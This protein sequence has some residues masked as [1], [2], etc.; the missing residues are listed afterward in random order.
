MNIMHAS[1]T[2]KIKV[3]KLKHLECKEQANEVLC[4]LLLICIFGIQ[5]E[6]TCRATFIGCKLF[7]TVYWFYWTINP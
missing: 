4:C 6:H 7:S 3:I 2:W 1:K 5:E